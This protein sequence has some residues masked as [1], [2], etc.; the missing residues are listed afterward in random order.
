[1]GDREV[2]T[3]TT[4]RLG[5]RGLLFAAL[6]SLAA[7]LAAQREPA[8]LPPEAARRL[9]AIVGSWDS[10]W[11]W[12]GPDGEVVRTLV[13]TEEASW[14][15]EGRVVLL[16]TAVPEVGS[17]SRSLMYYSEI[18]ERF[19]LVSVDAR[20]DL[21]LLSGGLEAYV[22]TSEPK[23]QPDGS[24]LTIRFTHDESD[25][26]R[27]TAVMETSNDGGRTWRKAV[28]QELVRRKEG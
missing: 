25:P 14:A 28:H 18:D 2:V 10:T 7:P 27:F 11:Q 26:D 20:G 24:E 23:P 16:A 12:L 21:W 17:E 9:E 5:A 6:V 1:M 15:I 19:H 13:G 8:E 22:I 3:M 4:I